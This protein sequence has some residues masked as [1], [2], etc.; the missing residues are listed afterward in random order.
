MI[1]QWLPDIIDAIYEASEAIMGVYEGNFEVIFKSDDS[2]VTLADQ[3]SNTI[4]YN[5]LKKTG[6]LVISEEENKPEYQ[7]RKGKTIWL[8]DPLD[9]TKEFVNK[10]DEFCICVA[11]IENEEPVFGLI[12]SPVTREIIFGGNEIPPALIKYGEKDIFNEQH[13]LKTVQGKMVKNIIYSRT[14]YTPRIDVLVQKLELEH[15]TCGRI[16]K[17]SALKF[18]DLV[19]D[20]AQVYPRL[21]PTMEWDIAA[22]HAIYRQLGGEVVEF[23]TFEPL[24]YNKESLYNPQFIAKPKELKID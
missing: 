21:W 9:G 20:R 17:G 12:A 19:T 13:L 2:P 8:L 7:E 3:Q 11:L 6:V 15:G 24:S 10:N 1:K 5:A 22:G 4:M 16:L 18:F 14:H 23:T